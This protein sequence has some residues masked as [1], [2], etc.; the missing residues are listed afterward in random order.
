MKLALP[1][2]YDMTNLHKN[3]ELNRRKLNLYLVYAL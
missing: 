3:F 2:L 1:L